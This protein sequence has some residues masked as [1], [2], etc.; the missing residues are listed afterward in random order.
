VREIVEIWKDIKGYEG[1][2]RISDCG[3]VWNVLKNDFAAIQTDYAGYFMTALS[4][5]NKKQ[6]MYFV[7][8]LVA[9]TFIENPLNKPQIHHID[10][11]IKNNYKTNLMWVTKEEHGKL[12]SQESK[13]NF[14]ETYKKNLTKRK[15][16]IKR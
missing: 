5:T 11:N 3:R 14:R 6:T 12:R 15:A 1:L 9:E 8:R 16:K 2:Y 4:D 10:E 7:H 13:D